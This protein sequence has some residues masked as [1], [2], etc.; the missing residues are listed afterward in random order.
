MNYQY[1]SFLDNRSV[2]FAERIF[3]QRLSD[4]KYIYN[5]YSKDFITRVCPYCES[6][7]FK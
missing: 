5:K 6:D 3:Q 2:N 7:Q 4:A 1:Y